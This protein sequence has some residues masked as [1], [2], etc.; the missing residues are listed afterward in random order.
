MRLEGLA[1]LKKKSN[2]LIWIR[3]RGLPAYNIV[4]QPTTLP[5]QCGKIGFKNVPKT[6]ALIM[7]RHNYMKMI[8]CPDFPTYTGISDRNFRISLRIVVIRYE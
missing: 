1:K 7:I 2:D 4:P 3:T 8:K 5:R 6:S